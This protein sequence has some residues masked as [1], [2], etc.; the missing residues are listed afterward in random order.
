MTITLGENIKKKR[1]EQG[2]T[3]EHLAEALEVSPQAVSRWENQAAYP[4]IELLPVIAGYFDVTVDELLGVDIERK[5]DEIRKILEKAYDYRKKGKFYDEMS[6]LRDNVKQYPNSADLLYELAGAINAHYFRS[7]LVTDE[8]KKKEAARE[9]IELCKRA[10]KYG[11]DCSYTGG[12][13]QLMV[14]C[15]ARL[16]EYEKAME[17]ADKTEGVYTSRDLLLPRA[18]KDDEKRLELWQDNILT[19]ADLLCSMM[20]RAVA[21]G[22]SIGEYTVEQQL[23]IK[24]VQEKLLLMVLGENPCSFNDRLFDVSVGMM[25][26]YTKLKRYDEAVD[27]AEKALKYAEDYYRPRPEGRTYSVFWLSKE[28]DFPP[29]ENVPDN[30]NTLV[31]NLEIQLNAM[32]SHDEYFKGDERFKALKEKVA[33]KVAAK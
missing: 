15:Y 26:E 33:A 17:I 7:G 9:V 11:K 20:G 16:G 10:L 18:T 19:F 6:W 27:S 12:C 30:E 4:D 14:F 28:V 1:T 5:E 24:Q 31:D 22:A 13:R 25:W 3:Q 23:E 29:E 21:L 32:C 2:I 8:D